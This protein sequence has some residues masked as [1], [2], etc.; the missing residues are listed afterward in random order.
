MTS[1]FPTKG[2]QGIGS[3]RVR[4][5]G[6]NRFTKRAAE[7]RNAEILDSMLASFNEHGCFRTRVDQVMA[8]VGIGKGTLYRH[9][10]SREDLFKNAL[11]AGIDTLQV[12]CQGIWETH[13]IDPDAG[14]RAVIGELVSLNRRREAVSPAALGRL[15]C[16]CQWM[17]KSGPEDGNLEAALLPLV[18]RWQEVGLVDQAADA[19]L[20]AAV[21]MALVNWP[22]IINRSG[23]EPVAG[24]AASRNYRGSVHTPDV[25]DRLVE[26]L[27]RAFPPVSCT[28]S[29][30]G[31]TMISRRRP[32]KR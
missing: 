8:R 9:Y 29:T 30:V 17:S 19:S 4:A 28:V 25:V 20:I 11:R 3:S 7:Q 6:P 10:P 5:E 2:S 16:G 26:F 15:G 22:A 1:I 18:R 23:G 24:S 14:F 13:G 31:R 32:R 12:R 27:R 21:I